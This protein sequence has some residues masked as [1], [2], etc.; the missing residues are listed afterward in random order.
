MND[1]STDLRA[2]LDG[3][4]NPGYKG[5]AEAAKKLLAAYDSLAGYSVNAARNEFGELEIN[6][7]HSCGWWKVFPGYEENMLTDIVLEILNNTH[8][9]QEHQA[10]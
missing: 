5:L 10:P 3:E 6:L 8:V 4:A 2:I 9:C 1:P 7:G